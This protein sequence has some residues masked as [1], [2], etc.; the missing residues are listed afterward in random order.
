M[1]NHRFEAADRCRWQPQSRRTWRQSCLET[2]TMRTTPSRAWLPP[3]QPR[4]MQRLQSLRR[5]PDQPHHLQTSPGACA[6]RH[7]CMHL[8]QHT[9]ARGLTCNLSGLHTQLSLA[10]TTQ[11]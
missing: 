6:S 8:V 1:R 9:I 11:D 4:P 5:T 10:V 3:S 7:A 2:A